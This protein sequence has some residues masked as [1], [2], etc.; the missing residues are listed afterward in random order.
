M[1]QTTRYYEEFLY[2]FKLASKQQELCNV[3]FEAP[4]GMY[5]HLAPEA[6]IGDDLMEHVELYDVVERKYA[7]FSQIVNDAFYGWTR[8]HPY[9]KKMQAGLVTRQ[10]DT[11]A[12]D[13]TG[14]K[15][16]LATWLYIFILHRVT[17][18]AINYSTKPTGY[19]NTI[20]F[21]LHRCKDIPEMV[22]FI[23][24][25]PHTF[26]TSVGYQFPSFPKVPSDKKY[27]RGGD[28]YLCEFAPRLAEDLA[29]FLEDGFFKQ[30]ELRSIGG[31]MLDWN[32]KHGLKKYHFQYAAVVADV[33]DWFPD[34]TYRESMFYYGSNAREC[35]SYLA[36]P[37]GKVRG[38][39][40]LDLVMKKI[41][42]DTGSLPYNAEDVCCDF[43]RWVENYIKPGADYNH[44]DMDKV[45]NSSSIK[46]HPFGRQKAML[47]LGLVDTFNGMANHPADDYIIK[48]AGLTIEEYKKKVNYVSAR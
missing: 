34:F 21:H 5:K 12:K 37:T 22:E 35:I 11:V 28:Y 30:H 9:W 27:K 17:G 26:Y 45:W 7:G 25:Y 42:E 40:F 23:K 32:T 2:Y 13:W 10:R 24:Y 4:Y 48:K 44:L 14:K 47:D 39:D 43:I 8:Y 19:H 20:L 41:Y 46:D 16:D 38:D 31:F 15:Y 36:K 33:A 29:K 6:K 18:S 1:I 3:S